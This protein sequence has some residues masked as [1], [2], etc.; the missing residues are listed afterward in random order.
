[1][2]EITKHTNEL[3]MNTRLIKDM[4]TCSIIK[5]TS[6]IQEARKTTENPNRTKDGVLLSKNGDVVG[7]I[8]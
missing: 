2:K 6:I 8:E 1:M 3:G 5:D 4:D 7:A